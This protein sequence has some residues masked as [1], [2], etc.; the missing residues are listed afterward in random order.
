MM[1]GPRGIKTEES[2]HCELCHIDVV[3][4]ADVWTL[5]IKGRKHIHHA[6]SLAALQDEARRTIFVRGFAKATTTETDLLSVFSPFGSVKTAVFDPKSKTFA[7]VEYEKMSS[8]QTAIAACQN[9]PLY[10]RGSKLKV[11]ARDVPTSL[12]VRSR[13]GPI[14]I[15]NVLKNLKTLVDEETATDNN[16]TKTDDVM[17]KLYVRTC[18][19][20]EDKASR[21]AA[22]EAVQTLLCTRVPGCEVR[23]YGSS[24]NDLG[25]CSCDLDMCLILPKNFVGAGSD[26][27]QIMGDVV[28]ILKHAG[29]RGV[30]RSVKTKCPI[31]RFIYGP[32]NWSCDLTFDNRL[33]L[34]NSELLKDYAN[35]DKRVRPLVYTL[36]AWRAARS[37]KITS[38]SLVIMA[39]RFLIDRHVLTPLESP[40]SIDV[41]AEI[42]NGWNV[43]H[44][45]VAAPPPD[46][47]TTQSVAEL[48]YDMFTFLSNYNYAKDVM[49]IN[50]SSDA[51]LYY[52]A[53]MRASTKSTMEISFDMGEETTNRHE[54]KAMSD[55]SICVQDPF[56]LSHNL[57]SGLTE[58]DYIHFVKEIE[59]ARRIMNSYAVMPPTQSDSSGENMDEDNTSSTL[60]LGCVWPP[61]MLVRLMEQPH[62][63][64]DKEQ[65]KPTGK[66]SNVI[67]TNTGENK[68]EQTNSGSTRSRPVVTKTIHLES[69][70]YKTSKAITDVLDSLWDKYGIECGADDWYEAKIAQENQELQ[71]QEGEREP[72][73]T[74]EKMDVNASNEFP[75]MPS[76]SVY[77][78]VITC[79]ANTWVG[80][81]A[82]R[83]ALIHMQNSKK[84]VATSDLSEN[85]SKVRSLDFGGNT[86]ERNITMEKPQLWTAMVKVKPAGKDTGDDARGTTNQYN[87]HFHLISGDKSSFDNFYAMIKKLVLHPA[88]I[89]P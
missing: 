5:H 14:F 44:N 31:V 17:R 61:A 23:L 78:V 68:A 53:R 60:P 25:G 13:D 3:G 43:T 45:D 39:L 62:E 56:E 7:F 77:R 66:W 46:N 80:G 19:T 36:K 79:R 9:N 72:S 88:D 10:C 11:K 28:D 35:S 57:T 15:D 38:Y 21:Q 63:L 16:N 69:E 32:D 65:C 2:R 71:K 22:C 54:L 48:M 37:V 29:F 59:R 89:Q 74:L 47:N 67:H 20:S 52:P 6:D 41:N 27:A 34:K 40:N 73:K 70:I 8:A 24:F 12:R 82:A 4:D 50:Q 33:A 86:E 30:G 85:R 51:K 1:S 58:Y 84:R 76:R 75:V 87:V 83:R 18:L 55:S 26:N 49:T 42:V 81:R 64:G